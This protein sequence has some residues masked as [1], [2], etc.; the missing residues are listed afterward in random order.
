MARQRH[1]LTCDRLL[2]KLLPYALGEITGLPNTKGEPQEGPPDY[3][4]VDRVIKVMERCARLGGLD[5]EKA[6]TVNVNASFPVF[7][8]L[9]Q[10]Q[11][12]RPT[13]QQII[14]A[15]P[16]PLPIA[17]TDH[18]VESIQDNTTTIPDEPEEQ[19]SAE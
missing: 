2:R 3:A 5:Q 15:L 17:T 6:A 13:S 18:S 8:I 10:S 1:L 12:A 11:G 19:K 7:N 4:A 9:N 16:P 14:D